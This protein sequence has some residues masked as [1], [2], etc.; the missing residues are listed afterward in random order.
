MT[1]GQALL[2]LG[3]TGRAHRLVTEGEGLLSA[4]RDGVFLAYQAPSHL[5]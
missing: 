3:D 4:A 5:D 1:S 2:D